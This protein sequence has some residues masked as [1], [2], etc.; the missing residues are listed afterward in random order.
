[1]QYYLSA[2]AAP[3]DGI[4]LP[5]DIS[6]YPPV[7]IIAAV[8]GW[9]IY[10]CFKAWKEGRAIDVKSATAARDEAIKAADDVQL[11][12]T[13]EIQK[14]RSE[15]AGVRAEFDELRR[16]MERE[17]AAANVRNDELND[18]LLYQTAARRH[19]EQEIVELGASPAVLPAHIRNMPGAPR[20]TD[21]T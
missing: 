2:A 9:V 20:K 15:I 21:I 12:S 19:R 6:S 14:L 3:A 5:S 1:M 11:R 16:E 17:R 7:A 10:Q 13:A 18:R 4:T 8:V